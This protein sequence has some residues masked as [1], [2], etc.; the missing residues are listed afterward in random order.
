MRRHIM[1]QD[2]I[3][4][5]LRAHQIVP[6]FT[7]LDSVE[8]VPLKTV[9]GHSLERAIIMPLWPQ[10]WACATAENEAED[11]HLHKVCLR[12][13]KQP[14]T[15]FDIKPKLISGSGFQ[16]AI[17]QL[18]VLNQVSTTT[19]PSSLLDAV[20]ETSRL[21]YLTCSVGGT[22]EALGAEDFLPI[23][24][25]VFV[26]SKIRHGRSLLRVLETLTD[27]LLRDG[28]AGYT[29]ITFAS[30]VEWISSHH[31][32]EDSYASDAEHEAEPVHPDSEGLEAEAAEAEKAE[33]ERLAA[34]KAEAERLEA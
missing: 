29:L 18:S 19:T 8:A 32:T 23:F 5:T 16:T 24:M 11:T 3:T 15:F 6:E 4:T 13:F 7:L 22:Q 33:A 28:N 34:E 14:Q 1:K 2:Q 9:V 27:P 21:I 30:A 26:Q 17:S 25:Y 12:L 31:E 10:L 20:N